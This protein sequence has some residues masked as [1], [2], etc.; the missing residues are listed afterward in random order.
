ML[1]LV[2]SESWWVAFA[3][4]SLALVNA[5]LLTSLVC[6]DFSFVT[7]DVRRISYAWMVWLF[8]LFAVLE[9]LKAGIGLALGSAFFMIAYTVL[10]G[11]VMAPL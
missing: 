6:S 11:A 5:Y 7:W 1:R 4:V 10:V 2:H 9:R 8:S 3:M